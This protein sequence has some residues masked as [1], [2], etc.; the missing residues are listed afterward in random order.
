MLIMLLTSLLTDGDDMASAPV[1]TDGMMLRAGEAMPISC[2]DLSHCIPVAVRNACGPSTISAT[3][4]RLESHVLSVCLVPRP[5]VAY[6]SP[7]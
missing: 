1:S 6:T 4:T 3:S 2:Y 7:Q 5:A